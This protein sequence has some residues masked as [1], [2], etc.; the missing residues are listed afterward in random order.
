[1]NTIEN[2]FQQYGYLVLLIGL[3]LEFIALPFPGEITMSYCGY[4]VYLGKMNWEI[5]I[6]IATLGVILG[7]TASYWIGFKLGYPFF[8]KYGVI[9]HLNKE[10]LNRSAVWFDKFGSRIIFFAYFF[11]GL[12]H[13]SGYFSGITRLNFSKFIKIS[14]L[15]AFFW[16]V[17]FISLGAGLGSK[18]SLLH[19][20]LRKLGVIGGSLLFV[21]IISY[22]VIKYY[23]FIIIDK[24]INELKL[25][26]KLFHSLGKIKIFIA[27]TAGLFLCMTAWM[28]EIIQDFITNENTQFD[29]IAN[30]L[31]MKIYSEFWAMPLR[32]FVNLASK[33]GI[34]AVIILSTIIILMKSTD[35]FLELRAAL[36]TIIGGEILI[37]GLNQIF[38][39]YNPYRL[40]QAIYT[41][42]SPEAMITVIAY[43]FALFLIYRYSKKQ[44]IKA[45]ATIIGIMIII[46]SGQGVL[47]FQLERPSDVLAGYIFGLVWLSLNIIILEMYRILPALRTRD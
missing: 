8:Y 25:L 24:V 20:S 16:T 5:S 18:W 37:Y 2:L 31:V 12:R 1:M 35:I 46:F 6:V 19:A 41:Y 43:G 33:Y 29:T 40:Y 27:L 3:L 14:Y 32:I 26:I 4:L 10:R 38:H 23:R 44:L 28:I 34:G 9:F 45:A 13:I 21:I 11:P 30:Y 39:K 7:I 22:Y 42:P 36:V 47:Y 17:T 15:G